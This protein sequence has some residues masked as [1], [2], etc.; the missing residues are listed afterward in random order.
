MPI[1][2]KDDFS[3]HTNDCPDVGDGMRTTSLPEEVTSIDD[4]EC[5]CWDKY[6]SLDELD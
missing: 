6:E 2:S 1:I 3:Y 4:L 5:S